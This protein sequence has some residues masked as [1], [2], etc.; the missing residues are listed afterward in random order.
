MSGQNSTASSAATGVRFQTGFTLVDTKLVHFMS[1]IDCLDEI[2][3]ARIPPSLQSL[4]MMQ[5]STLELENHR[6][7]LGQETW[8]VIDTT[9]ID[10]TATAIDSDADYISFEYIDDSPPQYS[11]IIHN[12][13]NNTKFIQEYPIISYMSDFTVDESTYGSVIVTPPPRCHSV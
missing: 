8:F 9:F 6:H 2:Q 10:E 1:F 4:A 11:G 7:L 13:K 3:T 12:H 5:L